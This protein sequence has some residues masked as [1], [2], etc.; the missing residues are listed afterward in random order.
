MRR[1][2]NQFARNGNIAHAR[3][4]KFSGKLKEIVDAYCNV[5]TKWIVFYFCWEYIISTNITITI[6]KMKILELLNSDLSHLFC[7][8]A[9][10]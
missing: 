4:Y 1:K 3:N 7:Q 2:L 5:F 10:K 9:K 8:W 6:S